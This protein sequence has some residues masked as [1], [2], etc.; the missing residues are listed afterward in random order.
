MVFQSYAL[1]PHKSVRQNLAFGL[2]MRRLP[3]DEIERRVLEVA[4]AL[5]LMS[6]LDR[7]PGAL[8]GGQRQ[9]VALGRAMARHPQ[10][11]L[12]D[13][14]LSNL[15]P[16]L[17]GETRTELVDLH[18]RLG[19]T[20]V[21]VTHDQ[22]EA[23]TLGQRVAVLRDGRLEQVGRPLELYHRPANLFVGGFIGSPPMN[24]LDGAAA[25]ALATA[26]GIAPPSAAG[27]VGVRPWDVEIVTTGGEAPLVGTID[28]IEPLGHAV[29]VHLSLHDGVRLMAVAPPGTV[30]H[31]G[32]RVGMTT[33]ADCVHVFDAGGRRSSD[34]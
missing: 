5:G 6:L 22:E 20:M 19:A 25:A 33:T 15:D 23:M 13:E 31:V 17:R 9:R 10:A 30:V 29:V 28:L 8:S 2:T 14:P 18:R 27:R 21:Y 16:R 4:A 7:M 3:A 12:F 1:Y 32:D 26:V 24:L 34:P 11:F